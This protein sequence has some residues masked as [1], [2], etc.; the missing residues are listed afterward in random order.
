MEAALR[1][2]QIIAGQQGARVLDQAVSRDD[3]L[4]LPRVQFTDRRGQAV[5]VK[6]DGAGVGVL[7]GLRL[8]QPLQVQAEIVEDARVV[9]LPTRER[10]K[11]IQRVRL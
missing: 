5:G 9:R 8:P 11:L 2:V 6:R 4:A 7:C 3:S 1:P 10:L